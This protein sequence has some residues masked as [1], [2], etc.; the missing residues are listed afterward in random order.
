MKFE[1]RV[2]YRK[3]GDNYRIK[4]FINNILRKD[5]ICFEKTK[6]HARMKAIQLFYQIARELK[7]N[8]NQSIC[9]YSSHVAG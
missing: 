7:E 8:P 3:S 5:L 4:A 6:M 1:I 2:T 9:T